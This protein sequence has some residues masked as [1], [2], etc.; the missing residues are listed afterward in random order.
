MRTFI[1]L[2]DPGSF[3]A[4]PGFFAAVRQ[5]LEELH[6]PDGWIESGFGVEDIRVHVFSGARLFP[7]FAMMPGDLPPAPLVPLLF[8]AMRFLTFGW[9][10]TSRRERTAACLRSLMYRTSSSAMTALSLQ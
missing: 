7:G 2:V 10:G 9:S 4:Q 3:A 8:Q 5:A 6:K 1:F